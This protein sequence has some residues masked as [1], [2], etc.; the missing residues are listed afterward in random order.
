MRINCTLDSISIQSTGWTQVFYFYSANSFHSSVPFFHSVDTLWS[1]T[2]PFSLFLRLF[3]GVPL[4]IS[5]M[6]ISDH[7]IFRSVF[8]TTLP[9]P[10]DH[11]PPP[12]PAIM[13]HVRLCIDNQG[14][15]RKV[16]VYYIEVVWAASS[17]PWGWSR[18]ARGHIGS[19][20]PRIGLTV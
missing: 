2:I 6:V 14:R 9:P 17:V 10:G 20:S 12:T 8:C 7:S 11:V 3:S 19:P 4:S 18:M 1:P 5:L 16:V 15:R 13:S